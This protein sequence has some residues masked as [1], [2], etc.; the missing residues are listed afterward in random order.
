MMRSGWGK[1]NY[2]I[3][4]GSGFSSGRHVLIKMTENANKE[5]RTEEKVGD[6]I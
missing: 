5:E 1:R 3:N 4:D 2:N 6:W